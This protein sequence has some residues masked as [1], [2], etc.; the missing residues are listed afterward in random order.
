MSLRG[1]DKDFVILTLKESILA[2]VKKKFGTSDNLEVDVDATT[3]D[4]TVKRKRNVVEK[5][6][7]TDLEIDLEKARGLGYKGEVGG[8]LVETIPLE[9]FGRSAIM[10]AKQIMF[11]RVREAERERIYEGFS[12]RI[13]DIVTGTVQQ[14]DK[15][16]VI[17]NLG[18]TEAILPL[19][20]QIYTERIRQ[21]QTVRAFIL[22]VRRTSKGPQV[23]LSR[24][25]PDFLKKLF[26]FEVPEVYEGVVQ[27]KS[28]ARE[29]G[30][31]SKIAVYSK[32][33]KI[34][35]VGACVGVKG[36]RVQAVVRE[37][38]GEKIDVV[39]WSSDMSL[40]VSRSLSPAKVQKCVLNEKAGN[41]RVVIVD[42]QYSLAIG[43]GGQNARLAAKL[44]GL[45]IDILSES[46]YREQLER[47]KESLSMLAKTPGVSPRMVDR[48]ILAGFSCA[49]DIAQATEKD[50]MAIK[51]I[52]KKTAE[53]IIARSVEIHEEIKRRM[54]EEARAAEELR[55]AA[56][57][58]A[59]ALA[60]EGEAEGGD[61]EEEE[62][63]GEEELGDEEEES[64]DTVEE[65]EADSEEVVQEGEEEEG[66]EEDA[67]DEEEES[68][69]EEEE[70][71]SQ[72]EAA[73]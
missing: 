39:Q 69:S 34:D 52:G 40:F 60:E 65:P 18:R 32:D 28:V 46:Q 10:V 5:V 61:E 35:P 58:E 13:G 43:R 66:L 42:D 53:K 2:G 57:A 50:L 29:P 41:A 26:Q 55:L 25:H 14:V 27:I 33:D 70:E 67:E 20:E 15:R 59:R 68:Q 45:K 1:L 16:G 6:E 17:V 11:Q 19:R 9:E 72:T 12:E 31:R 30:D 62:E 64:D 56:E 54:E 21:G 49:L 51:G 73:G 63:E 47:D 7:D 22:D 24:T 38:N 48:L 3:G 4:I 71:E 37:L 36:S 8:E 23:V 44:T